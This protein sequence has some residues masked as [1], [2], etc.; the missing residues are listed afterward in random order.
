MKKLTEKDFIHIQHLLTVKQMPIKEVEIV[1][2]GLG[3]LYLESNWS[4]KTIQ[5]VKKAK[6]WKNYQ[7]MLKERKKREKELFLERKEI[8]ICPL[9]RSYLGKQP[10]FS[11]KDAM[12]F[13]KEG[14]VMWIWRKKGRIVYKRVKGKI[15]V[16]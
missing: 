4:Y 13:L 1:L 16:E 2:R 8:T 6:T 11:T 9:C 3:R 10:R 14:D 15:I 7:K 5:R 12:K